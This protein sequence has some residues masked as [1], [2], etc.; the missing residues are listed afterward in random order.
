MG[1]RSAPRAEA[2]ALQVRVEEE[3]R[4]ALATQ[5]APMQRLRTAAKAGGALSRWASLGR[6][7][8]GHRSCI[9]ATASVPPDALSKRAQGCEASTL[10]QC[11]GGGVQSCVRASGHQRSQS[12]TRSVVGVAAD[13]SSSDKHA[14]LALPAHV[15]QLVVRPACAVQSPAATR[16]ERAAA[17]AVTAAAA[18]HGQGQPRV[19]C[20]STAPFAAAC[21]TCMQD[22]A[23]EWP[24]SPR[25]CACAL[26]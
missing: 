18:L 15:Q 17:Y 16:R 2:A 11:T 4:P 14:V 24:H 6:D 21:K 7:G 22:T 5:N 23:S 26:R 25:A 12:C 3:S 13:A 19:R 10:G 20:A 1:S 9:H 8:S